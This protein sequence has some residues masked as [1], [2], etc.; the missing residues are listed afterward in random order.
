M[1]TSHEIS[2]TKLRTIMSKLG[3]FVFNAHGCAL[4]ERRSASG[5]YVYSA[6][7]LTT[8]NNIMLSCRGKKL[9]KADYK[10][11]TDKISQSEICGG[12]RFHVEKKP[13]EQIK[14]VSLA[15]LDSLRN[16]AKH[17]FEK[18]L[19]QHGFRFR[20]KQMELT[21]HILD[22]VERR[23]ISLAESQ[24]GTG[25]THAYLIAALIAKRGR[26]ND[27][28]L[29]GYYPS[30]GWVESAHTPIVISTSSIALQQAIVSDYIP[31]LSKILIQHKIINRPLVAVVRKGREHYICESRL[32][33]YCHNV[34][35]DTK[36]LLAK[37][38]GSD[39][40]FDLTAVNELSAYIKR[41]ICVSGKCDDA[42][43]FR[44]S[45]R[46]QNYIKS[47]NSQNVDFQ[48]TNHNYF[49]ADVIHRANGKRPL[50]PHYQLVIIDEAHKFLQVARQMYGLELTDTELS[51][52]S[53]DVH[54]YA[55]DKS[56]SGINVHKLAKKLREQGERL[57]SRLNN[58]IP[59]Q[60]LDDEA[61]RFTAVIDKDVLRHLNS[62]G[63]VAAD[64]AS[65]S[66]DY[67][68][69]SHKRNSR[70]KAV[71]KLENLCDRVSELRS[72]SRLVY[73]LE[74]RLEG[75]VESQ[76]LCA[77]PKDLDKRL[78]R[79]LWSK[80]IPIILTSG[81]L[82]ASGDF[83]RVKDTL[84]ICH[85][86]DHKV[87]STTMPSPFDYKNNAMLYISENTPFPNSKDKHYITSIADEIERLVIASHGHAAVLFTSYN[88]MGQV[89]AILKKRNLPFPLFRLER[90][91]TP[92]SLGG[93][94]Y[95]KANWESCWY[96]SQRRC[97][98]G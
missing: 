95:G 39:S 21:E 40:P 42:C 72:H 58:N 71:W 84:G 65:A 66:E 41:A 49:L 92:L 98:C 67:V 7:N 50:L 48:I 29:R 45:C 43:Y 5:M 8:G 46:Y 82:S 9:A 31:E 90:G 74:K 94:D 32:T 77:I 17:I 37:Y 33:H 78:H 55:L 63:A 20:D 28:W 61:E 16:V 60:D 24:V 23:A 6:L 52:V 51:A 12:N 87:F 81:T 69:H 15:K 36:R 76:A 4:L 96:L 56:E 18:I 53:R 93:F 62:I 38:Q 89:H 14:N 10:D 64:I 30:Q 44:K 3:V 97:V 88:A 57:F 68:L 25:K 70:D 86:P 26:L 2:D 35:N 79:D 1:G 11:M 75:A 85:M 34:E 27:S 59:E 22:V 13:E 80:G 19:P 91:G 83:T 47:A 73:W 54:N